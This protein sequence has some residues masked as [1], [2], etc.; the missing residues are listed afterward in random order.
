MIERPSNQNVQRI[1]KMLIEELYMNNDEVE[2]QI[3]EL[4][5]L[6]EP[7]F[8]A[9]CNG[10]A[11]VARRLFNS[12]FANVFEDFEVSKTTT[13]KEACENIKTT[14]FV[15]LGSAYESIITAVRAGEF[16]VSHC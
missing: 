10:S 6:L 11:D 9:V 13:T 14:F 3:Y 16:D 2:K 12:K 5:K 8:L 1:I 15:R 4:Y 7:Q